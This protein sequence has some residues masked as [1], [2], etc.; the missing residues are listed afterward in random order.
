MDAPRTTP[1]HHDGSALYVSNPSPELG[2]KV[3]VLVRTAVSSDVRGVHV[4]TRPDGE[5]AFTEAAVDR[6]TDDEIWWR[7]TIEM[8]NVENP[9]RF[10]LDAPGGTRWLNGTGVVGREVPDWADFQLSTYAPPPAWAEGAVVYQTFL[11]RFARSP[12]DSATDVPAWAVPAAWDEP[13]RWGTPDGTRQWYGGTLRGIT[14]A[15][16]HIERLGATLLYL[17]PF[18]PARSNH[19]YDATSFDCVDPLLGG[20]EALRELTAEAHRR[21]LRVIGDITLNHSGSAHEWFLRGQA[22]PDSPEAGFYYFEEDRSRYAMFF[23]VPS[24]AKFDHRCAALR[25][26]LYDGG[27]SAV[28]RYL[29]EFGL[30][31][32]RVDVAQSAGRHGAVELNAELA[33]LT[34]RTMHEHA[35]ETLLIAEHQFDASATLRGDGWHGTMDYAGFTRPVWSWLATT[36]VNEFWGI[37]GSTPRYTGADMAAVMRDFAAIVPWRSLTHNLTLLD[38]HDTPRFRSMAG[39]G[40]QGVG[41]ALQMTLPGL[42]MIFAGDEVGAEGVHLEDGR[43]PFSWD[44]GAW[45][46]EMYDLYREL[47]ALRREHE[48][49]RTGGLRWLHCDVDFVLYER[50]APGATVLVQV[51]RAPHEPLSA[52]V[53]GASLTGGPDLVPGRPMP[54]D[55]PAWHVWLVTQP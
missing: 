42:P 8:H 29:T 4:R 48:A 23:G 40:L 45:D 9:Y 55:G 15:M 22:D 6:T 24:L 25:S 28:A 44:V 17:T 38:S 7:A 13:I 10:L 35:P 2:D 34:R 18:F 20:D 11:D 36:N 1:A 51:S 26:R 31:G 21:G 30:D 14:D 52:A 41:V 12:R 32:W 53:V 39:P 19:R 54:A 5:Q 43:R 50:A 27:A 16:D 46:R 49:L 33:R 47:I 37:P 3:D